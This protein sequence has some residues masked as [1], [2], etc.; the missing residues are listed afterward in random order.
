MTG[1][2]G[3][4]AHVVAA[5]GGGRRAARLL[6]RFVVL[7]LRLYGSLARWAARRPDIPADGAGFRYDARTRLLLVVF[8]I[9][10][11]NSPSTSFRI[12]TLINI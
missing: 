4:G 5:P 7:E 8:I 11:F 2:A 10:S 12:R 3:V 1:T 9:F 6:W